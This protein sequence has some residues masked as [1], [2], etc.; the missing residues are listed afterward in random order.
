MKRRF[1]LDEN[2]LIYGQQATNEANE[3]DATCA[4]LIHRIIDICHTLVLDLPLW[5]KYQHQLSRRH[6]IPIRGRVSCEF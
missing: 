6:R 3:P 1:I 2:V 5:D 4:D